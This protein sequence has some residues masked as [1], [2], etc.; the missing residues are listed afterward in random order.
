L[1]HAFDARA[2]I[3][4]FVSSRLRD[5]LA[6]DR[7]GSLSYFRDD[8]GGSGRLGLR[9]GITLLAASSCYGKGERGKQQC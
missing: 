6:V 8:D 1:Q 5:E 7:D 9:L 4:R 3:H 2:K